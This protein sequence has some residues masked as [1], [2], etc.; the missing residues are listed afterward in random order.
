M[1]T[2]EYISATEA[3]E[4]L[5]ISPDTF[6]RIVRDLN[7]P[8]TSDPTD[9]RVKLYSRAAITALKQ[10]PVTIPTR[11]RVITLSNNKG[12]VGKT[13]STISLAAAAA[14]DGFRVLIID[15]APQANATISLM[16]LEEGRAITEHEILMAW[17]KGDVAFQDLIKP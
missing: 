6:R 13:T 9:A 16:E 3:I 12:G 17:L 4:F 15:A 1:A 2:S 8:T 10:R 5:G 14:A 11:H 7:L